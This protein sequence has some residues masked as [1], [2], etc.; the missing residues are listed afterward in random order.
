MINGKEGPKSVT[1]NP[2]T[3]KSHYLPQIEN[4]RNPKSSILKKTIEY[5]G[6]QTVK[7]PKLKALEMLSFENV[8]QR[9]SPVRVRVAAS[10]ED[11]TN[12]KTVLRS[13]INGHLQMNEEGDVEMAE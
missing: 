6:L 5:P 4:S 8:F 13:V 10:P 9:P 12:K 1:F 2:T 7:R 3:Y 11:F